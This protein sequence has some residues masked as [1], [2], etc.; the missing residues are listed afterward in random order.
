MDEM[1]WILLK[2]LRRYGE[3]I[4]DNNRLDHTGAWRQTTY[5]YEDVKFLVL[6]HNGKLVGIW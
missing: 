4:T 6:M 2:R 3:I 5:L 1:L